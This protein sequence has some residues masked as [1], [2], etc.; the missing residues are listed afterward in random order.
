MKLYITRHGET[1]WNLEG[2]MQ[3][4]QNSDLTEKGVENAKR[5]GKRLKDIEFDCIYCSPLGRAVDTAEYI[6]GDK[7]T[8]IIYK[9]NLKEMGF[10]CWEG[11]DN[12]EVV[13]LYPEQKH[14][15]WHKPHLYVPVDGE[16]YQELI[17]RVAAVLK[18]ITEDKTSQNVL[19]VTHAAVIKALYSIIKSIPLEGFWGEPYMYDTCL[20]VLEVKDGEISCLLEADIS[21]LE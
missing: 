5:L 3:G 10:G 15:F 17:E 13:S 21:H 19:V 11:R 8:K 2:R 18:E 9:E 20:T 16:S 4:W 14:N 7:K 1:E 12:A 6:M